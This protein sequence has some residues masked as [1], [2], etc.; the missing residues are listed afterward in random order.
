M[1]EF[2]QREL[3]LRA[4]EIEIERQEIK[5]Q[6]HVFEAAN[7]RE[8]LRSITTHEDLP[9]QPAIPEQDGPL[10]DPTSTSFMF[11]NDELSDFLDF[12]ADEGSRL[13][14]QVFQEAGTSYDKLA[15]RT[16]RYDG[17]I[18]WTAAAHCHD[19]QSES[20]IDSRELVLTCVQDAQTESII[21]AGELVLTNDRK[22][23]SESCIGSQELVLAGGQDV[24]LES[25]I[26]IGELV[27][28][29]G[30]NVQ[31]GSSIGSQELVSQRRSTW[32]RKSRTFFEE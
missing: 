1:L 4:R 24:Q 22:L 32:Q 2:T 18:E 3:S 28:A 21:G 29:G 5:L 9:P 14:E 11:G 6:L 15:A 7:R 23:Q 19:A 20:S 10:V 30:H 27:L 13:Q 12:H 25:T 16:P 8:S 17:N 26:G 31:S